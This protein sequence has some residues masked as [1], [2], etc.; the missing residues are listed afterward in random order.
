MLP[1]P[2]DRPH[3]SLCSHSHRSSPVSL[4]LWQ[5]VRIC[6][7]FPVSQLSGSVREG[8]DGAG[9]LHHSS[10]LHK[11]SSRKRH[12]QGSAVLS[13][14][15]SADESN[16]I[17]FLSPAWQEGRNPTRRGEILPGLGAKRGTKHSQPHRSSR[18][19]GVSCTPPHESQEKL[20]K[21]RRCWLHF[22]RVWRRWGSCWSSS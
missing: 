22:G 13:G 14:G 9:G 6:L 10:S 2:F 16:P 19:A 11:V 12:F 4:C 15:S 18:V 7:F 21:S 3:S 20:G 1:T 5:Q 8:R 17:P